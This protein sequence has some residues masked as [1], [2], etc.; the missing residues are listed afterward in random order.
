MPFSTTPVTKVAERYWLKYC[1]NEKT[2]KKNDFNSWNDN[3]FSKLTKI[4]YY[5]YKFI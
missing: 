4:H 2:S 1:A 3:D 5:S